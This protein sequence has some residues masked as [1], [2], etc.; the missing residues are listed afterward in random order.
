VGSNW[1]RYT[2]TST[3]DGDEGDPNGPLN[4]VELQQGWIYYLHYF[5]TG[6][7]F[8]YFFPGET[9]AASGTLSFPPAQIAP[10]IELPCFVQ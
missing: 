5:F 2:A 4:E 9:N 10:T 1:D 8:I 6:L 7:L 3:V